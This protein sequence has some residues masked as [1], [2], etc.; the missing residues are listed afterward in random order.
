MT[1]PILLQQ[2]SFHI[3]PLLE[4][5]EV[6]RGSN[7]FWSDPPE[8]PQTAEAH[9]ASHREPQNL[10]PVQ[11]CGAILDLGLS[12]NSVPHSTQWI[13][14]M[15]LLKSLNN[16]NLEHTPFS[17]IFRH[18][19]QMTQVHDLSDWYQLYSHFYIFANASKAT[20]QTSRLSRPET[21]Q[22]KYPQ[23]QVMELA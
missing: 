15:F 12:E 14:I 8:I 17:S 3:I 18:P 5:I 2:I 23:P 4:M 19:F 22:V 9:L 16:D 10:Q 6:Y 1:R 20:C 13:F 21:M 11:R 7:V